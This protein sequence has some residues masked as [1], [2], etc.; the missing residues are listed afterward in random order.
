MEIAR[1]GGAGGGAGAGR[2]RAVEGREGGKNV[3]KGKT[4][5]KDCTYADVRKMKRKQRPAHKKKGKRN[6]P[7][8]SHVQKGK[9]RRKGGNKR[10]E[11][12]TYASAIRYEGKGSKPSPQKKNKSKKNKD[13]EMFKLN[14]SRSSCRQ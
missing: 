6:Q 8:T 9:T 1:A 2:V 12:R 10:N 3:R 13:R 4:R 11:D 5:K 14:I 7:R